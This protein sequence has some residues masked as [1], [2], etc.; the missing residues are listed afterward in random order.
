M[1]SLIPPKLR[2]RAAKLAVLAGLVFAAPSSCT[3]T[4]EEDQEGSITS[5]SSTGSCGVERWAVKV[6]TDS[7]AGSVNMTPQDTTIAAL[8]ALAVP[9]GLGTNA[10]R[11][12]P[13]EFQVYR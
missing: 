12:Q 1:L 13:N 11:L 2:Q 5:N 4:D 10:G 8:G 3:L 6:G 7:A 9:A